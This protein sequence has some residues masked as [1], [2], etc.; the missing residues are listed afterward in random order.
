MPKAIAVV[1]ILVALAGAGCDVG[2][3]S[4]DNAE[5]TDEEWQ[6][7][8]DTFDRQT[9]QMD[10]ILEQQESELQRAKG[11]ADRYDAL[12]GKW[13]EQAR[14]ADAILDAEAKKAGIKP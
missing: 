7:Q 12:L 4:G 9:E 5:Y 14:R 2:R 3:K 10:R 11:Q 1:V 6:A 13:E 8:V